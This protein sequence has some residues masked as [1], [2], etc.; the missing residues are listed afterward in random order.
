M[1]E[2]GNNVATVTD[3]VYRIGLDNNQFLT[4]EGRDRSVILPENG[5]GQEWEVRRTDNDTYTIQQTSD[6]LFL[7]FDGDPDT[8]E[9]VRP[10]PQP[11]E[12]RIEQGP[13]PGSFVIGA[14]DSDLTVGLHPALIYPPMV[15]LSPIFRQDQGWKFQAVD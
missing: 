5:R 2:S 3:G 11:R 6:Q 9:L 8:F 15:A 4:A 7:G 1:T 13:R 12:W 10:F 14:V